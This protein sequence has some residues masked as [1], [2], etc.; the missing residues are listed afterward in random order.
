MKADLEATSSADG[1]DSADG[2]RPDSGESD[3]DGASGERRVH[4]GWG[5]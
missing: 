1:E 3:G 4:T 5:Q 2:E